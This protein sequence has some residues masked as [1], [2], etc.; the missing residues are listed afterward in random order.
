[1]RLSLSIASPACRALA[2]AA[3]LATA[4]APSL[5]A[6][7][8]VNPTVAPRAAQLE[9]EGER[10]VATD[11]L[12]RYLATAPDDGR[13]WFH[14]GRFYRIDAHDWHRLGH[15]GDPDGQLYLDLARVALDQAMRLY[16]DSAPLYRGMVE[17]DRALLV[18]EDSGWAAA[19]RRSGRGAAELPAFVIELGLNLLGSCPTNGVLVTGTELE[20]VA[21]WYGSLDAGFRP[22]VVPLRPELYATDSLYRR[23]MAVALDV[24]AKLPV[25]RALAVVGTRRPICLTP[26][27]DTAAVS[28]ERWMPVR[29]VRV[30][31][32]SVAPTADVLTVTEILGATRQGG[33]VWTR[34][35]VGVYA[36]AAGYNDL[37]CSGALL[38]IGDLPPGA[39]RR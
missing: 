29:L 6:Q 35:V 16:I 27:A 31:G 15:V 8:A 21:V 26:G 23:Q 3:A 12:G 22:D 4:A 33:T 20:A 17:M 36:A 5:V 11:M 39:C 1:M 9:R 24:D 14:L 25:R 28:A 7:G 34:E 10:A 38:L 18:V 19:R 2:A 37:L 13:A 30:G 32:A